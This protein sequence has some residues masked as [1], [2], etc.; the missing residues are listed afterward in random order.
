MPA[1]QAREQAPQVVQ[2]QRASRE[3]VSSR[4]G[5]AAASSVFSSMCMR[6]RSE[7]IRARGSS[8][9][10]ARTAGQAAVQRPHSVQAS[11]AVRSRVVN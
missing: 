8:G 11:K 2:D 6:S 10:P 5:S 4:D 7:T 9:V 1:G 3:T